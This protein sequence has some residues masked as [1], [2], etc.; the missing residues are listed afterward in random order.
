MQHWQVYVVTQSLWALSNI[1]RSTMY[2]ATMYYVAM[3]AHCDLKLKIPFG[4]WI[5]EPR[6]FFYSIWSVDVENMSNTLLTN[7]HW[8]FKVSKIC[9][10]CQSW[11]C[12]KTYFATFWLTLLKKKKLFEVPKSGYFPN[13]ILKNRSLW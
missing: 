3:A 13:E 10:N 5:G 1:M 7:G 11:K 12:K 8:F 2:V 4:N 9:Q 6:T